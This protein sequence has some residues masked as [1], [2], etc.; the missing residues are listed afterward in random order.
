MI[1][2]H[3]HLLPGVDD[4]ATCL[5]D[6]LK[7]VNIAVEDGITHSVITPHI[8]LNRYD[9]DTAS[10]QAAFQLLQQALVERNIPFRI[11]FA[12]EVRI[13]PAIL[14][15]IDAN[16]IPFLGELNGY[17]ILLLEFP[18]SGILPGSIKF[19]EHLLARNIRPMIA[20]PERNKAVLD[21][22]DK[23]AP[24]RMAG[25]LLQ[26]TGRSIAGGFG[27]YA[28][29]RATEM[30]DRDWVDIVATDAHNLAHR[31]PVSSDA[32]AIVKAQ[33]GDARA[34]ALFCKTPAAIS[35]VHFGSIG[36]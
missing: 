14:T 19:I 20:H 5:E 18:H 11:A 1:D 17:K 24:M 29:Q 31:P 21:Q 6:S 28:K 9:N 27:P 22:L 25:A 33:Y 7:L 32:Y 26:V 10:I 16:R 23:I 15:M 35:A 36:T 30:L 2:L 4:G 13:D 8:H 34:E 3:S 12:A